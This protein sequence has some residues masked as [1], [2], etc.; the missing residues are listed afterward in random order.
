MPGRDVPYAAPAG[1]DRDVLLAVDRISHR[2]GDDPGLRRE[3]P[4]LAPGVGGIGD[5]VLA[6]V[7]LEHE[8]ARGRQRAAVPRP[9]EVDPPGLLLGH[10]IP[11]DQRAGGA[12]ERSARALRESPA[13]RSRRG[14]SPVWK[15]IADGC[16]SFSATVREAGVVGR[17]VDQAGLPAVAHRLP[18][19]RAARA[20]HRDPRLA[21]QLVARLGVDLGPPAD[22]IDPERPV[23][24]G[25]RRAAE[26]LA[27]LGVE[28]VEIAV[29]RRMHHH[30]LLLAVDGQV[31]ERDLGVGIEVPAVLGR[32]LEVPRV[33]AGIG[34][35]RDDRARCR[36][37][38]PSPPRRRPCR[39]RCRPGSTARRCRCRTARGW[40]AGS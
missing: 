6:R 7:A 22:G 38:R 20:G 29:L 9:V 32:F 27:G 36:D 30:A 21:G 17:D 28:D 34:V 8:V 12:A 39:A 31:G 23:L 19:M 18:R 40:C 13:S 1:E 24:R 10:R 16:Q 26:E 3:R 11:R 2:R 4:Q 14:S 33:F 37:C 5:E 15:P 25:P 35:H